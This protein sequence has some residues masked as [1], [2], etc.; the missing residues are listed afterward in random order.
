[1]HLLRRY[2]FVV[3]RSVAS[4]PRDASLFAERVEAYEV[5]NDPRRYHVAVNAVQ[6]DGIRLVAL[7]TTGHRA[8]FADHEN[9]GIV[10]AHRG[11]LLIDDG[12]GPT[13]VSG[14]D[15]AL[16][17]PG[18]RI[19]SIPGPYLG[20]GLRVP[21]AR[22]A[23]HVSR[24][25][26]DGAR[27]DGAWPAR[28]APRL[29]RALRQAVREFDAPEGLNP[30]SAAA[31]G[32]ARLLL[33][34][35]ADEFASIAAAR[36]GPVPGSG[37]VHVRRAEAALRERLER[38]V[39]ILELAGE[40]GISTRSLQAGFRQHRGTTPRSFLANCR[41]EA[42]RERL[43]NARPGETVTVIAHDCGVMHPG[44]FAASYRLRYGE[45]PSATLGR[46]QRRG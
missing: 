16:W 5:L 25:P 45:A 37:I 3:T 35:L 41:L 27:L 9:F 21:I 17:Q 7:R 29:V 46:A 30:A 34:I 13:E 4:A 18:R 23:A 24:N 11:G 14:D 42:V 43:L 39:S 32:M 36:R 22:L 15:A 38:P 31:R 1:M 33:D 20:L 40:L 19:T 44:R 28:P 12:R 8:R 6:L 2:P 10:V 26:E